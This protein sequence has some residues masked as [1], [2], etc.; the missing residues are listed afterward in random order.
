MNS[1]IDLGD[2]TER[3][4]WAAGFLVEH[5]FNEG[6]EPLVFEVSSN[7]DQKM[8]DLLLKEGFDDAEVGALVNHMNVAA[9]MVDDNSRDVIITQIKKSIDGKQH[10]SPAPKG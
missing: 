5:F 4:K 6:G 3:Q 10:V 9:G 7:K 8:C 2:M 1:Y